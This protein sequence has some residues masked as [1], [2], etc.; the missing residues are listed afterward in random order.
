MAT[1]A[2]DIGGTKIASAIFM[3]NGDMLCHTKRLLDKRSGKAVGDLAADMLSNLLTQARYRE[4]EIDCV[5]VCVPGIANSRTRLVWA[6]NI[7]GW[8]NYP[9]YKHLRSVTPDDID[10]YI[11]SDRTCYIY[12]E[13]WQG[14]A[15]NCH[16]AVFIAVGTGIGAG[17]VLDG[18][19]VHG[20]GDITGATG[21]M[22]L[23]S[24]YNKEYDSCGCFEYYASGNGIGAR[25]RD[26]LRNDPLYTGILRSKPIDEITAHDVFDA[27][28]FADPLAIQIL[29]KA[30]ELWGM[31]S[32]NMVSLLNPQKI[33]WGGGVFGPAVRFIDDIYKEA[34]KWAQPISIKEVEYVPSTL[35]GHAGLIGAAYLAIKNKTY[36]QKF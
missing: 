26:A 9:L 20:A 35:S 25:A 22:A 33:I 36:E 5:G 30:I 7:P 14:A 24:P 28:N 15:I 29:S 32:A 3:S 18:R 13:M 1:I 2:L 11:D 16:T 6:P 4:I 21:W 8:D 27:Y 12:G 34:C 31:A 23:Q 19:M 17:I 10:I